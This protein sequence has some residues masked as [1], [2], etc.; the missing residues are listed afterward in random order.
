MAT[1]PDNLSAFGYHD[2]FG[3]WVLIESFEN[4]ESLQNV[5]DLCGTSDLHCPTNYSPLRSPSPIHISPLT[6]PTLFIPSP[7]PPN[8]AH[9]ITTADYLNDEEF[10]EY[11]SKLTQ[12]AEGVPA[13]V[14]PG[15]SNA[16]KVVRH[17]FLLI[18]LQLHPNTASWTPKAR[19]MATYGIARESCKYKCSSGHCLPSIL[20]SS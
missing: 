16:T 8:Q 14:E 13:P 5:I 2:C 4:A 9:V 6:K 19:E 10:E 7:S 15:P 1:L 3:Y 20:V 18:I 11:F 12:P 17:L